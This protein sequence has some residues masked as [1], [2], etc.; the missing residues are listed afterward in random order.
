MKKFF[1]LFITFV[2]FLTAYAQDILITKDGKTHKVIIKEITDNKI[3]YVDYKDPDGVLF[4]IDKVLVKEI[5]FHTGNRMKMQN[6]EEN[7]WYFAED[8][9]NNFLFNFSAFGGNTLAF[10]YER[11]LAPGQ[12]VMFEIKFYGLG[13]QRKNAFIKKHGGVGL[14]ADYRI[15]IQSFFKSRDQYRPPHILHGAYI[16]PGIGF[17]TGKIS[18]EHWNYSWEDQGGNSE[19]VRDYYSHNIFHFGIEAGKEFVFR[20]VLTVDGNVGLHYYMGNN[21]FSMLR[22][23]NLTGSDGLLFAYN[24]RIGFLLGKEHLTDKHFQRPAQE[25]YRGEKSGNPKFYHK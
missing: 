15:R 19:L 18:V 2:S 3:K 12:S 25:K 24:L 13:L 21:E 10:S 14:T 20:N 9:I 8:K 23:G 16:A 5:R 1:L 6:P 22:L 4:T 17:S 7:E 11:A